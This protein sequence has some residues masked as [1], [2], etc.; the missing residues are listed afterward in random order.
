MENPEEIFHSLQEFSKMK[1]KDIPRELE[2]YLCF[3]AKTGNTVYQ[4]ATIKSLFREKLIN[5]ITEF[6]E[7]CSSMDIPPCPN[8]EM[9]NYDMMKNFILE[10][11]DTFAAAPFTVQRICELLT[12]PRKEYN[13]IDKYMRALEKNILVVSTTEPGR[14]ST[15]NGDGILN[16]V[17]SEH[18]PETSNSSHDINIEDMD[19]S[20]SNWV[21]HE[22]DQTAPVLYK[23]LENEEQAKNDVEPEASSKTEQESKQEIPEVPEVASNSSEEEIK[24]QPQETVITCTNV[25]ETIETF[26]AVD[27]RESNYQNLS[28]E[29]SSNSSDSS[30][31]ASTSD[32]KE[33]TED[34][35]PV[36]TSRPVIKPTVVRPSH[37]ITSSLLQ[38]VNFQAKEE[39]QIETVEETPLVTVDDKQLPEEPVLEIQ[40]EIVEEILGNS[41]DTLNV[42][43]VIAEVSSE[44]EEKADEKLDEES[45][46]AETPV[47]ES[48]VLPS[49][50]EEEEVTKCGIVADSLEVESEKILVKEKSEEEV[51]RPK[52]VVKDEE[53]VKLPETTV[54]M[55]VEV[56][57][58]DEKKVKPEESSSAEE[59]FAKLMCTYYSRD[60]FSE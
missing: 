4:W 6:Y 51:D 18:L 12:T 10:K 26:V 11:L 38:S 5:V 17:E 37:L 50:K 1:P 52:D 22:P 48:E 55:E 44:A 43:E 14:R 56:Q 23:S 47:I 53:E 25:E 42:S 46:T 2:E 3:V 16:G 34:K 13:R 41:S 57:D 31:S 60:G 35:E 27:T 20:A 7:S 24:P 28:E 30:S 21:R 33:N 29:S 49:R 19:E 36:E 9:F 8:V 54:P 58:A 39:E 40:R 45:N 59:T 15:E 32:S